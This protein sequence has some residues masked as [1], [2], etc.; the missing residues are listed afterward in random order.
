MVNAPEK[1]RVAQDSDGFW[2]CREAISGSQ[3]YVRAD[4]VAELEALAERLKHEAQLH[5]QEAR[6]ANATIAEIYREVSGGKGE[7]GN[8]NGAEPVR[9]ELTAL[10][11]RVTELEAALRTIERHPIENFCMGRPDLGIPGYA[12]CQDVA[13]AALTSKGVKE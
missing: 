9:A 7:P 6:T 13:R 3:E 8:W 2:T 11:A 12:S 10:R 5:A 4:L 1:I